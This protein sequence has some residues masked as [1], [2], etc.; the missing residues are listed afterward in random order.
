LTSHKITSIVA[1]HQPFFGSSGFHVIG[2]WN[3]ISEVEIKD[4]FKGLN[5]MK[6][7]HMGLFMNFTSGVEGVSF[8][9]LEYSIFWHL[10]GQP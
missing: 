9:V 4:I 2:I 7:N 1:L 5:S 6:L 3:S 8:L 10:T